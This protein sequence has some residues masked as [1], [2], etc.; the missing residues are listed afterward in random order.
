[1]ARRIF[2]ASAQRTVPATILLGGLFLVIC[3]TLARTLRPGEIPL[4]VISSLLGAL[5][6][7]I[8]MMTASPKWKP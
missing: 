7:I 1:V 8:L 5:F 3:D 6:F 2:G 4:G